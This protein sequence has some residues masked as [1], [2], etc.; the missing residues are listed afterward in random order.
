MKTVRLING[1]YYRLRYIDTGFV[2]AKDK[3]LWRCDLVTWDGD[4]WGYHDDDDW[5]VDPDGW[6]V[7]AREIG[8]DLRRETL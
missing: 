4:H 6:K 5:M 2:H 3:G 7:V 1:C 8:W